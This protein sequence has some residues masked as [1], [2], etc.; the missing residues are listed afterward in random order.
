MSEGGIVWGGNSPRG[1]SPRGKKSEGGNVLVG[2]VRVVN[3]RGNVSMVGIVW[4]ENHQG[5]DVLT[6]ISTSF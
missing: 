1:E 4:W 2:I 3:V 5:V 6:P